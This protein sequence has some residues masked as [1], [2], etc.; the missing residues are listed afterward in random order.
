MHNFIDGTKIQGF[1]VKVSALSHIPLLVVST[2][3]FSP[4]TPSLR[5]NRDTATI[6]SVGIYAPAFMIASIGETRLPA[7]VTVQET[8]A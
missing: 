6:A 4:G 2:R 3:D 5:H 8:Q 7:A 1:K